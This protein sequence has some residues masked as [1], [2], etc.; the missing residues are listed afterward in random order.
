MPFSA[1]PPA[2]LETYRLEVLS[3]GDCSVNA[4]EKTFVW[5][6]SDVP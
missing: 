2:R 3:Y 1:H 6:R 5:F 4:T